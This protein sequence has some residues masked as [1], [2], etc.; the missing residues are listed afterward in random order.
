MSGQY[1]SCKGCMVRV[2]VLVGVGLVLVSDLVHH[3]GCVVT[4]VSMDSHRPSARP[5]MSL[6]P[7]CSAAFITSNLKWCIS[8]HVAHPPSLCV[9]ASTAGEHCGHTKFS[10]AF[11]G[12][13]SA[14]Q[15]VL[16]R[17]SLHNDV[18]QCLQ[19]CLLRFLQPP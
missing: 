11:F 8:S 18:L 4:M 6:S 5:S 15:T 10:S 17:C 9:S 14:V 1:R 7:V 13:C 19:W 2:R 16:S 3:P 12:R